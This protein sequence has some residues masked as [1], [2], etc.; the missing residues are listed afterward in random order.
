MAKPK[1]ARES[2]SVASTIRACPVYLV[3]AVMALGV[4]CVPPVP[5]YV[6]H[7]LTQRESASVPRLRD[8]SGAI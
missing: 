5:P 4:I 3:L 6:L 7:S 1:P 8:Y 2:S